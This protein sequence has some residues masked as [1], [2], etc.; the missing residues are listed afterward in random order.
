MK[1]ALALKD[2]STAVAAAP[3]TFSVPL[4]DL[5]EFSTLPK[6]RRTEVQF[7][8]RVLE[9]LH[10]AIPQLGKLAALDATASEYRHQ[11][12]GC[13]APSLNRKYRAFLAGGWRALVASYQG[14]S[15]L[16]AEFVQFV[17]KLAE[18]N[19]RSMAE[20]WELLRLELWPKGQAIPNYGTWVDYYVKTYPERPLPTTC[21]RDFFPPGWSKRN[22]YRKAPTKGARVLFQRGMAAAKKHFPSVIRDPSHLRPMELITL[23]DF[24]LD[25]LC[26]FPG[27]SAHPPQ[28]GRVAG[29][30]A[31]DV[32]TRRKLMF[33]LGQR[34]ERHVAQPDGTFRTVR[35]G[36]R[37]VD[38]QHLLYDILL[39]YGLPEYP[40]TILTSP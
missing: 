1:T 10:R 39:K 14:P 38:V 18:D 3:V 2:R 16:P 29:L 19:H 5:S 15:A 9:E 20:A 24:E 33:G 7:I 37:R 40:V 28:I 4:A 12:R 30:L 21:P 36:I 8:L 22:L 32:G 13:A 26:V 34:L 17:K 6:A 11:F 35:T 23:D 25:C 31:I 27:D